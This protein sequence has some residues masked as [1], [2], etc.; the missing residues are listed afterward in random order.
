MVTVGL[1]Q[2]FAALRALVTEGIQRGHMALHARNI[3]ISAGT[4]PA[5]VDE[6]TAHMIDTGKIRLGAARSYI[7]K[8]GL[9]LYS[10]GMSANSS[11]ISV[12]SS[13]LHLHNSNNNSN[14]GPGRP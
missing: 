7:E 12:A 11:N 9:G 2:N 14:G 6:V 13:S 8:R 5:S 1:T 4:P 10:A 3:A